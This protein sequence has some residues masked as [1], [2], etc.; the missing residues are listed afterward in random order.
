MDTPLKNPQRLLPSVPNLRDAGGHATRDGG[1]VRTGLLYRSEQ[2]SHVAGDDIPAYV[3]LGLKKIYDLR[4][5][6]ERA[7]GADM[8]P[9]GARDVVLDVLADATGAAPAQLL[10][11]LADPPQANAML[12]GGK[13]VALFEGSYREFVSLPSARKGFAHLFRDLADGDNL[14]ALFHCTTGKDRTGWAAAALLT[15]CGV[16]DETV[17]QDYLRSNDFILP[18]YQGMIDQYVKAGVEEDILLSI[19]GVRSE[20]LAAAFE[21]MHTQFGGIE[22]YFAVGLGIGPAGQKAL[23]EQFVA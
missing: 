3:A 20:Y 17:L 8:A 4:T 16:P 7:A 10:H 22:G 18:E 11:L 2:L 6:A 14:P 19:L 13:I 1:C 9:P 23:R 15:L 21:E 5:A 12:G